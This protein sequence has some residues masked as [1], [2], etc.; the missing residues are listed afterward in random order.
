MQ[1]IIM[2]A[3]VLLGGLAVTT[4]NAEQNYGPVTDSSKGSCFS[5]SP[6]ND[7]GF[8]FWSE[9]PKPATT[10]TTTTVHHRHAKHS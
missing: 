1:R 2:T 8:G 9:C 5:R 4:A 3:A 6:Y 10:T 7:L